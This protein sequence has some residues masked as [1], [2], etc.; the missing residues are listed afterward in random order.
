M[1][2]YSFVFCLI[3]I[4]AIA[5]GCF[6]ANSSQGVF[7]EDVY[8]EIS[9]FTDIAQISTNPQGKFRLIKDIDVPNT[10]TD[11]STSF[12]TFSGIIDG[13]GYKISGLKLTLTDKSS[14]G[15]FTELNRATIK[16]LKLESVEV[17]LSQSK[18][19]DYAKV[20]IL[21]G[22]ISGTTI[23]NISIIGG[24]INVESK[25]N[26]FIGAI[27]GDIKEGSV[28]KNCTINCDIIAKNEMSG[29]DNFIGG[30]AGYYENST[31]EFLVQN[32][33]LTINDTTSTKTYLGGI[34][35]YIRG[36]GAN[37]NSVVSQNNFTLNSCDSSILA[38]S[39]IGYVDLTLYPNA[40]SLNYLY[41]TSNLDF[42]GNYVA[43]NQ[44]LG[45]KNLSTNKISKVDESTIKFKTFYQNY[46]NFNQENLWD[47]D[48]IWQIVNEKTDLPSLQ[49]FSTFTYTVSETKSFANSTITKPSISN[50]ISLETNSGN[51]D[52][53][54]Y[55]YNEQMKVGGKI[56]TAKNMDKFFKIVGLRKEDSLIFDNNE[57]ENVI[58][59][60]TDPQTEGNMTTYK[61]G[62]KTVTKV[63]D[64]SSHSTT[65]TL[66]TS[67]VVWTQ[68]EDGKEIY[69]IDDANLTN[70]GEYS[71]ALDYIEY[72]IS[73][74]SEN[75]D[76]GTIKKNLTLDSSSLHY[77]SKPKYTASPSSDFGFNGWY[78]DDK[79]EKVLGTTSDITFTFDETAFDIGG[80]FEGL[81]L[82]EDNLTLLATFTKKVC[83]VTIK[84]A[85]NGQIVEEILSTVKWNG[86]ILQEKDGVISVKAKM[87]NTFTLSVANIGG[88]EFSNWFQSDEM[89]SNGAS[90]GET[91]EIE[92]PI[93]NEDEE[94]V[95]VAN[96]RQEVEEKEKDDTWIWLVAGMGGGMLI[97]GLV[98]F[99]IVR[100]KR[101]RFG[102]GG[103]K[104]DYK[105]MFY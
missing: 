48:S 68:Y 21:A 92:I 64:N 99:F 79:K 42:V 11:I 78:R 15:I 18:E 22:S 3:M 25:S 23:Q 20:G 49:N 66:S 88:Y 87:G 90:Y 27:A 73:V 29:K 83:D 36:N 35:G 31:T 30:F 58:K 98:I 7:A 53:G 104:N 89:G 24:K 60:D 62:G 77:G 75:V 14:A 61:F 50:I 13:N 43:L 96:F 56:N 82:G 71:L 80:I 51:V 85:V 40:S 103:G 5:L 86:E 46:S 44:K 100:A 10:E 81:T 65:Y 33:Q 70:S 67:K 17:S 55:R 84:F 97:L 74:T 63:E 45:D 1:K 94:I 8:T 28:V 6:G 39:L 52:A 12:G 102:G 57:V 59:N 47:F 9:N 4:F 91:L 76:Q 54:S 19:E 32:S 26:T 72:A 93:S 95:I 38:Y 105:K 37:I 16:N 34:V 2:K 101:N 41:T 69:T